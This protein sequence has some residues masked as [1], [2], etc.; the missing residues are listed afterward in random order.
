MK[1]TQSGNVLFYV[2]LAV[3]LLGALSYVVA[4]STRGNISSLSRDKAGLYASEIIGYGNILSQAVSQ[5]RL[6]GYNASEISFE[7][8]IVTGYENSDCGVGDCRIFD[9]SGGAVHYMV[10]KAEWLDA[11]QAANLR[12]GEVYFHGAAQVLEVGTAQD[13]LIMF[14]PYIKKELC[15]AINDKLDITPPARDVP[16]ETAGPFAINMKFVGAYPDI[17]DR[18]VSGDGSAGVL[19][20]RMVGCTEA[21]GTSSTPPTGSYHYYQVLI[22]R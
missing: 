16:L 8:V 19:R 4:Q 3:G 17:I 9:L 2:F 7:N 18:N 10:P 1:N 12:Y 20:G 13:D 6:R 5:I 11:S 22:A 14:I 15:I 21:S